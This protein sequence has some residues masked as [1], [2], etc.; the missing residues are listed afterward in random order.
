[1][2]KL[3]KE[4]ILYKYKDCV[5]IP[6]LEFIDDVLTVT[7]CSVNSLKMNGS[8]QSKMECKKLELS[9][10]KCFK[11]HLEKNTTN[12]PVL[13]VNSKEMSTTSSEKYLGD[14]LTSNAKID[15]NVKMRHEKGMGI[16]NQV[17]STLKDISFGV[18]HF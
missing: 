18:Y 6:P 14:I 15:E 9:E 16:I 1:M 12:C 10:K 17:I 3:G 11:M 2:A 8:V 7:K 5:S 4:F 13:R